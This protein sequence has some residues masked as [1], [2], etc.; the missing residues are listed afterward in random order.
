MQN[1]LKCGIIYSLAKAIIE[2]VEKTL[3]GKTMERLEKIVLKAPE[4]YAFVVSKE[5]S[6]ELSIT[7]SPNKYFGN[8]TQP[9]IPEGWKHVM[10]RWSN[11]F[12]IQDFKGNQFVWVP[13]GFLDANGTL[14]GIVFNEKFG[15]RN[16]QDDEFSDGEFNE[17]FDDELRKQWDSVKKYGGFYISRYIISWNKTDEARSAKGGMP[18]THV[19]WFYARKLA[20]TFGDGVFVKSHLPYGAEYDSVLEWF[21][22][23]EA[24]TKEEITI[25]STK[26]GNFWNNRNAPPKVVKTGTRKAWSTNHICDLAGNVDEWTNETNK[27]SFRVTRGGNCYCN[28][29]DF[30]VALREYC[31]PKY[32]SESTGFRAVLWLA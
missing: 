28:G 23:S 24:R 31:H 25:D 13:V 7:L 5:D 2:T 4:D 20:K 8:Y 19:T 3:G 26:W 9:P 11:G 32:N 6:G 1:T 29:D 17:N 14:D 12:V 16:Y 21:L 30:P 15:R 27:G 10:G 22:K 18:W